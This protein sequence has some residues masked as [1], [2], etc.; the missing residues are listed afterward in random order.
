MTTHTKR[1]R[2]RPEGSTWGDWGED[3]QLGRLNLLTPARITEA[4]REIVAGKRFCLSLP[5]D[6]PGGSVLAPHR[7]PPVLKATV[8]KGQS[9]FNY[10]FSN[11]GPFDDCGNDDCVTLY[12]Q[13]STQWDSLAHVGCWFDANNTGE[14]QITY[15]NGYTSRDIMAPE[16]RRISSM[17]LGIHNIAAAAV[18]GRGVMVDLLS[19][20]GSKRQRV[21]YQALM[22]IMKSDG[23]VVEAG[24]ILCLHTGFAECVR[25][26]RGRPDIENLNKSCAVL[27]GTDVELLQWITNS[28]IAAIAADNYAVEGLAVAE[29]ITSSFMVPLHVHCLFKLGVPLGELWYFTKLAEWLREHHRSRFFLT[30]PPLYLPGAVGSPVTP[31]ATV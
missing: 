2:R 14:R 5:L 10:P 17:P 11:E 7:G 18:Q 16:E 24:D 29:G 22:D 31:V 23:V 21:G 26:M 28:G 30:A 4:A 3:D 25:S 8:R 6:Y 27:D 20:L 1:W 15:Y 12:S 13:Y 9:F 19:H